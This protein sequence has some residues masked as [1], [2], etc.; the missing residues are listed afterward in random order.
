MLQRRTYPSLAEDP[1]RVY[2]MLKSDSMNCSAESH[3][4]AS[5][6]HTIYV[7]SLACVLREPLDIKGEAATDSGA[8][9]RMRPQTR[10]SSKTGDV[11]IF[12]AL[13]YGYC[14]ARRSQ[15]RIRK[16]RGTRLCAFGS[17]LARDT[18]CPQP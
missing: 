9:S 3:S 17:G 4:P 11:I 10:S 1:Y 8:P 16:D 7:M 5:N 6:V 14:V 2:V 15:Y 12:R 13:H 18:G